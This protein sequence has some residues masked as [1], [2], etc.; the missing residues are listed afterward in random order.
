MMRA[1]SRGQPIKDIPVAGLVLYQETRSRNVKKNCDKFVI[2]DHLIL[3]AT[4]H[5]R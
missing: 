3:T 5:A 2:E 4:V 1:W